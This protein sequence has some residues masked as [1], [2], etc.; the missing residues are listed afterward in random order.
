MTKIARGE[1]P[2]SSQP[3]VPLLPDRQEFN[4]GDGLFSYS[5]ILGIYIY[6]YEEIVVMGC[7]GWS[8]MRVEGKTH[9]KIRNIP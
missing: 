4:Q 9:L 6:I 2:F 7:N 8:T 5:R 1:I 3:S